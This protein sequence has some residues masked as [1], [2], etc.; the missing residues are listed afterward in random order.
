[1]SEG[2]GPARRHSAAPS[3]AP[4]HSYLRPHYAA[5]W[6]RA[7]NNSARAY[8]AASLA[9]GSSCYQEEY[10]SSLLDILMANENDKGLLSPTAAHVNPKS[11]QSA[12]CLPTSN[13]AKVNDG[14]PPPVPERSR[15]SA[16]PQMA[17]PP[18]ALPPPPSTAPPP[19]PRTRIGPPPTPPRSKAQQSSILNNAQPRNISSSLTDLERRQSQ[20]PPVENEKQPPPR[21]QAPSY[22][23][24]DPPE[25]P[26][27]KTFKPPPLQTQPDEDKQLSH[28]LMQNEGL[29]GSAGKISMRQDS[30]VSSDSFSQNSSPS[31]TTKS[32]ETPLLAQCGKKSR[33]ITNE[34][35]GAE[36]RGGD[37]D[38]AVSGLESATL[39]DANNALTKS[40][41]T[42]AS[43]QAIVRFHHGSNMSIHH[44]IINDIRR[45][46]THYITR[47]RLRF[48]FAQVIL[49]A[50]ALLA[51]AGGLAAY[52]QAYP[53]AVRY[54]NRT[55]TE[56]SIAVKPPEDV[57]PAPG[58]CLPVIVTFCL[59]HKIPYN[60]TMFPNYIGHFTQR[61]AQQELEVYD[62]V[63]DVRC[64]ELAALFLCSVFVPKCG[65]TGQ[66][67]RPCKNLCAETKRRCGFFLDV[68]GLS[69]PD[70]LDCDLFPDSE[71]ADVC[72]GNKEVV[73]AE[74]RAQKPV[75]LSGFQCDVKRCI[76]ADWKCD[77]HVDC[78]DQSDELNCHQCAK[79]MIHCG[80]RRCMDQSHM[81]DGIK[82]C[83]WGQDER[84]CI[85]L[86]ERMGDE[87]KGK[88]EVFQP[89]LQSWKP[90]CTSTWD[91]ATP[92]A[93]CSMLGYRNVTSSN[94]TIKGS[95]G[96]KHTIKYSSHTLKRYSVPKRNLN[97]LKELRDCNT[98]NFAPI[99][100][101]CSS[102]TCGLRHQLFQ[103]KKQLRIVGGTEANPGDWPFLAA[104]LGGPEQ[105][106][107][108]AGVLISDQW[109]LTASHCVGNFT[110][111][112]L[113][114]WTIQLG[115]TRRHAH[116]YFGQKMKVKRVVPHPMYN[117]GIAH[118][119]D[120]A[121]FQLATR[122]TFHEHLLPVCLPEANF[123]LK[124]GRMCTV[125]GWGKREDSDVSEYE[126]AVN[127][128]Q[129]PILNRDLCNSWLEHRDLNVTQ[130]MICAGYAEGG[131]DA[132]QGDS[133]G[134]LLCM[135]D[136]RSP[137]WFVGGIVSW[138][139]KC[140]HPHL[141]GVYAYVPRY[142]PWIK[143]QMALYSDK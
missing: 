25:S 48:Q 94:L 113:S 72:V 125:I 31:Y 127:E 79:G 12:F 139:I 54:I 46:S 27:K 133:G 109:V 117:Q 129:V 90:A 30:N 20:K 100:L 69:L 121:L 83:P 98:E 74:K 71:D 41:S 120:V 132:C 23:K 95:I 86:S 92:R 131:K 28:I 50:V 14:V 21:P 111:G 78:E 45:P 75:C 56:P 141:P 55:I 82:D 66:L 114:G 142:V 63:E 52:F 106:F 99:E 32:M 44:R 3:T 123:K 1:M 87:G 112:D 134:P 97:L 128:V 60:Y 140:A 104:L 19:P 61:D 6:I 58:I 10:P 124:E 85:R 108:C 39:D 53:S 34:R 8:R 26:R 115:I 18:P 130:G 15:P 37:S 118:D 73:E 49:N 4:G 89:H 11:F 40:H 88:L 107:Y 119:N 110:Q 36:M 138:G 81:C 33:R 70:Y 116:S 22:K 122:V 47:G 43:L 77:G 5:D 136:D 101:G 64:Y 76:P 2:H 80:S 91:P 62:A 17:K 102:F 57:N 93:I 38:E 65:P 68:F 24:Y 105:I 42:P 103:E 135:T 13:Y 7:T 96:S 9:L 16:P 35:R 84:N 143:Q 137:R 59:Q 67:V 51:I 126:A 29:N